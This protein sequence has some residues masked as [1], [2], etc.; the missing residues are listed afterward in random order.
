MIHAL[1]AD[2]EMERTTPR[3]AEPPH[4]AEPDDAAL[5]AAAR[6]DPCA[7]AALY[8]RYARPIYRYCCLRLESRAAAEDATSEV[9]VKALAAL[10]RYRDGAF[11]AWLFQIA[12]NVVQDAHRRRRLTEPGAA[13][14]DAPDPAPTPE[15]VAL[16][17]AGWEALRAALAALPER[18]RRVVELQVA[19][20]S[21]AQSA[22]ALGTSP[23]T[24]K[25]MRYR[26]LARLRVLLSGAGQG[27]ITE[28]DH[29]TL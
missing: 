10:P 13:I 24:V 2:P 28:A 18:Q 6:A 22:E 20:W 5:V 25:V 12:H 3:D 4:G 21:L 23:G 1:P 11:A 19:G 17:Q 9:F 8:R 14:P 29:D 15:E 26:A 16:G 7:F 27:A